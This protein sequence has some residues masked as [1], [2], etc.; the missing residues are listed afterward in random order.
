MTGLPDDAATLT[1]HPDGRRVPDAPPTP[2][3]VLSGAFDPLHD[4]HRR[5]LAAA[6]AHV[7]LPGLY[8]LAVTNADKAPLDPGEVERRLAQFSDTPVVLSR[9]PLF[10]R[11][12]ALYPGSVLVVGVDTAERIVDPRYYDGERGLQRALATIRDVGCRLLV[13]G[14]RVDGQYRTL[15]D[16]D[17]PRHAAGLLT[18]LPDFRLDLSSTALRRGTVGG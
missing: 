13:A 11:K 2:A 17:V 18:E 10:W 4:G 16:L 3:A 8:E 5:L 6:S 9:E 1:V 14:R 15:D 7:R 12:A